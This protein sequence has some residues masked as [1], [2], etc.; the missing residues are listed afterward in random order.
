MREGWRER[1]EKRRGE[2]EIEKGRERDK[3]GGKESKQTVR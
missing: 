1:D 3:R 2:M